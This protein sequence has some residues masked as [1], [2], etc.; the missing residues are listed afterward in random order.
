MLR[1]FAVTLLLVACL[2]CAGARAGTVLDHVK[3]RGTVRCTGVP[4]PGLA[5][6]SGETGLWRGLEIDLCR[7]IA[8][9]VLG[10]ADR[11]SFRPYAIAGEA[12]RF[13]EDL[14]VAFLTGSEIHAGN[15]SDQVIP[16]PVVFIESHAVMVPITAAERG[17]TEI[18]G[19]DGICFMSGTAV[20]HSLPAFFQALGKPWR[21]VPFSEAGEMIDAYHVQRC[22]ALADE[23]TTLASLLE[24]HG[25]ND[26]RSRIL[27]EPIEAYPVLAVTS[28]ADGEWSAIVA[29]TI[30][31][32][33]AADRRPSTW[34][35]GGADA[36]PAP[37]GEVG[38][39][40]GWQVRVVGALGSYRDMF[41]RTLGMR[42]PLRLT[43]GPNAAQGS[44]GV[45]S[46]PILE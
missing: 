8:L 27:P 24:D 30:A 12:R 11:I 16:G 28:T 41:D 40:A 2:A 45:L 1:S 33:V 19:E 14:D 32:L 5:Q 42:S 23:L 10:S 34:T 25:I 13:A 20:E 18:P 46:A 21:P 37:L 29:W 38:L 6:A 7:A 3:A 31:T 15:L 39:D 22:H 43:P 26:L 36:M 17:V 44:G 35:T 4:R 9:A